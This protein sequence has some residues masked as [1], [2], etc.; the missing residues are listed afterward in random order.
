MSKA[1]ILV[2]EDERITA[3]NIKNQLEKFGYDVPDVVSSGEEAIQK[4]I[5]THPDLV[6]MDIKLKGEMDGIAA[7]EQIK[8][9]FNIPV[10]YLTAYSDDDTLHRAKVTEPYSYIL[11]PL[12]E[13][14]LQTNIEVALYKHR[15][16]E[17]IRKSEKRQRILFNGVYNLLETEKEK[18]RKKWTKKLSS[19]WKMKMRALLH[20]LKKGEN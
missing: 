1:R 11:K 6:L 16:D 13:K 3:K 5:E 19:W 4:A 10:I 12:R 15:M 14:E 2:V 17:K 7:A 9:S 20:L 18:E 8:K